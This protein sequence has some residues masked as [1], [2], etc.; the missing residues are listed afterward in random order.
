M[1]TEKGR[2]ALRESGLGEPMR[3]PRIQHEAVV[4]VLAGRVGREALVEGLAGLRADLAHLSAGLDAGDE[5]AKSLPHRADYLRLVHRLGRE[6]FRVHAEW[7]DEVERELTSS[8]ASTVALSPDSIFS[9]F[10]R[11]C[12]AAS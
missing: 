2:G 3:F 12:S 9:Q 5:V 8:D 1:L 4:K 7:A 6:P 10:S 11:E